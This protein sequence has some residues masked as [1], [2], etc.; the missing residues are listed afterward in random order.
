MAATVVGADAFTS[1]GT[2]STTNVPLP[3]HLA[4][5]ILFI[6]VV[7]NVTTPTGFITEPLNWHALA[8]E[9]ATSNATTRAF[10]ARAVSDNQFGAA[11]TVTHSTF[12]R[13]SAASIVVRGGHAVNDPYGGPEGTS[14]TMVTAAEVNPIAAADTLLVALIGYRTGGRTWPITDADWTEDDAADGGSTNTGARA[15]HRTSLIP[16]G[17]FT[18]E[19]LWV[20]GSGNNGNCWTLAVESAPVAPPAG[21]TMKVY[22]GSDFVEGISKVWDGDEWLEGVMKVYD[23]AEFI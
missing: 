3:A 20:D 22:T 8:A 14:G 5:D 18:Q 19:T 9:P 7:L 2:Q 1:T 16:A 12:R 13:T 15:G 11:V 6:L 4:G 23:G 17:A 10:W 21:A